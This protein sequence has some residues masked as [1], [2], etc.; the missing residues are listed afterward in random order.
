RSRPGPVLANQTTMRIACVV[1]LAACTTHDKP[2]ALAAVADDL[3]VEMNTPAELGVLDN[4]VGVV[5]NRTLD[6]TTA[7]AHGTPTL[8]AAGTLHFEPAADY[9][10]DDTLEYQITNPDGAIA[11]GA[12][13][14]K[15]GCRT[16]AIG[17]T[18]TLTWDPNAP[19]DNVIGYRIYSGDTMDPMTFA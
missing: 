9:L 4:D 6:I 5:D 13:A 8:D 12:V 16:C 1:F 18:L 7:P 14:I 2:P 15:V 11:I 10:G 17:G 3:A 19:G